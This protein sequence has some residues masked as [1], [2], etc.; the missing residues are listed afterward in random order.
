MR[1]WC[2]RNLTVAWRQGPDD[3]REGRVGLESGGDRGAVDVGS[4]RYV[5]RVSEAEAEAQAQAQAVADPAAPADPSRGPTA[6]GSRDEVPSG[7]P[8]PP[9][10]PRPGARERRGFVRAGR[11]DDGARRSSEPAR[12]GDRAAARDPAAIGARVAGQALREGTGRAHAEEGRCSVRLPHGHREDRGVAVHGR[13]PAW[14]GGA[15][16]PA[17]G[18]AAPVPQALDDVQAALRPPRRNWW[19]E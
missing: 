8:H 14:G 6:W 7:A 16:P 10:L 18:R 11:G 12:G 19:F 13:P 3:S 2:V 1:L 9:P 15:R 5:S 17:G 4:S